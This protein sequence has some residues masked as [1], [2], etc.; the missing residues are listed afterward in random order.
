MQVIGT[1]KVGE[2]VFT[3]YQ[4]QQGDKYVAYTPET[5]DD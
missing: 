5:D 3:I 4:T 1:Y 2:Q